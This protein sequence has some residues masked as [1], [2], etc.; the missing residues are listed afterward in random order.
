MHPNWQALA[1]RT[2]AR[3]IR[4][5]Q[6][7]LVLAPKLLNDLHIHSA[8]HP[9]V[10]DVPGLRLTLSPTAHRI[11]TRCGFR[12]EAGLSEDAKP[13]P[14]YEAT[15]SRSSEKIP[16]RPTGHRHKEPTQ[17]YREVR[18]DIVLR[19][20]EARAHVHATFAMRRNQTK[21]YHVRSKSN[22]RHRDHEWRLGATAEQG[23]ASHFEKGENP[24]PHLELAA[25]SGS[26][27]TGKGAAGYRINRD[28]VNC[29]IG[30]H[31][32]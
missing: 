28:R 32:E 6:R 12:S 2:S 9:G 17:N 26:G 25:Q 31:V 29:R 21:T 24:E 8:H 1:N 3:S 13:T 10:K 4:T 30:K 16:E 23:P 14:K 22:R 11:R 27:N 7:R 5:L 15:N 18:D 19:E 20:D